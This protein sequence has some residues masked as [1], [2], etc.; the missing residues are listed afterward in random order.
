MASAELCDLEYFYNDRIK[1]FDDERQKVTNYISLIK[2]NQRE[3]H[4]LQWEG[5]QQSD[6]VTNQDHELASYN[7]DLRTVVKQTNETK[8]ELQII[9]QKHISNQSQLQQ[10]GELSQPV[11]RDITY[12]FDDKYSLVAPISDGRRASNSSLQKPKIT[13]ITKA[14][15]IPGP[16]PGPSRSQHSQPMP[17]QVHYI[18]LMEAN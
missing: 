11:Q 12:F 15:E 2:P 9:A 1:T 18:A 16:V 14:G 17:K 8:S 6:N 13:K 10:L 4:I 7:D 3:L 5:K